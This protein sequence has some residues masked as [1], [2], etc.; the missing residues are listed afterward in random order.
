MSANEFHR[1]WEVHVGNFAGA[2]A[3]RREGIRWRDVRRDGRD[4]DVEVDWIAWFGLR[5][6]RW[7]A[8][9]SAVSRVR[10]CLNFDLHSLWKTV[11]DD[12]E[13]ER[14]AFDGED[15]TTCCL[16]HGGDSP[17]LATTS[18]NDLRAGVARV[19]DHGS[20]STDDA[21]GEIAV[22]VEGDAVVALGLMRSGVPD[23]EVLE[24][25]SVVDG[26]PHLFCS[27]VAFVLVD[28]IP[29]AKSRV[30]ADHVLHEFHLRNILDWRN[31]TTESFAPSLRV[32]ECHWR[33]ERLVCLMSL[34]G[35]VLVAEIIVEENPAFT[36]S[37]PNVE[38]ES[39]GFTGPSC[40]VSWS[41]DSCL[42]PASEGL[43]RG[44]AVGDCVGK[45]LRRSWRRSDRLRE[46]VSSRRSD[47]ARV[48]F[49]DGV[50]D[51]RAHRNGRRFRCCF[52]ER[53]WFRFC[54]AQGDG[55]GQRSRDGNRARFRLRG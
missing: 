4:G 13:N 54:L 19:R 16:V 25:C 7:F 32:V 47:G 46:G 36:T 8:F 52:R 1:R 45:C 5:A 12:V 21:H 15:G 33:W 29:E 22:V 41:G 2:V 23:E 37:N 3:E 20:V 17:R 24:V 31:V 40:G 43:G 39:W 55:F 30:L 42:G 34:D 10:G 38:G 9:G 6:L 49:R 53:W 27:L 44:D 35:P 26:S 28:A 14:L 50:R 11:S 51:R 48:G 18:A